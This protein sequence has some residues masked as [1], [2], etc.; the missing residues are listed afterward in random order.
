MARARWVV[1]ALVALT[2]L[3]VLPATA[4]DDRL[5]VDVVR[6]EF[7][8][9]GTTQ[10]VVSVTGS[11][12]SDALDSSVFE[13]IEDGRRVDNVEVAGIEESA[14]VTER[15]VM[16]VLDT[17]GSTAGEALAN[18]K[19]GATDFVRTVT[20]ARVSVG[21]VTFADDARLVEAPTSDPSVLAAQIESLEA[22]G[23]TALF[24]GIVVAA[25]TLQNVAGDGSILVFTD[26]GDT[27]SVASLDGVLTAVEAVG[28]PVS[29]VAL[30]T[31]DQ[32]MAPLQQLT[33]ATGGTLATAATAA[34]LADAFEALASSLTSQYILSYTSGVATGEFELAVTAALGDAAATDS[35]R[36]LS[37]RDGRSVGEP[38]AV[39]I[40][41]PGVFASRG[42]LWGAMA[43]LLL[44]LI[45]IMGFVVV[46]KGDQRVARTLE[47]GGLRGARGR[48]EPQG[49]DATPTAVG[50]RAVGFVDALPKPQGYDERLQLQLDRG[51]WPLRAAEFT[52]VRLLVVLVGVML[53]WGLLANLLLG[54]VLGA[55]GWVVPRVV[56]AQRVAARKRKFLAQLPDTL[57]LLAGSLKAGYGI[58]Q[59]IDTIVKEVAEPTSSEFQRVLVEARL[60]L[61]LE[62]SLGAMAER[63][64]SDDFRWVVVAVNIQRRVGGNLAE[65]LETVSE[66]LREREQVRRQIDVLSA[67]GRLSAVILTILPFA[68]GGYLAIINPSY[69]GQLFS[70]SVG[71]IMLL[72]AA[73][74]MIAGVLWMRRLIAIDV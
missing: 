4:Q 14:N 66:T 20:A 22:D 46:P 68:I 9:D 18:A 16:V 45:V 28:A 42:V 61:A 52:T 10:V 7:E 38:R 29:A 17:S 15:T 47:R 2:T 67:E 50:R 73:I 72:G 23:E 6:A 8:E 26:G 43:A 13:V 51:A 48:G 31:P 56:L 3:V 70:H 58:L 1:G 60:G 37:S 59:G 5:V 49:P 12:A 34:S 71:Q 63:L 62:D 41:D 74:L 33:S 24:D 19:A 40:E 36:L 57:Q 65:L 27:V 53:G 21:L 11:A 54:L 44:A 35:V 64:D 69:I 25:R 30:E 55:A 39:T 32:D